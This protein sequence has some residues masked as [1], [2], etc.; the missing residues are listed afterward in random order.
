[1]IKLLK[2]DETEYW[3]KDFLKEHHI[4]RM[5]GVYIYDSIARV[6]CCET[7]PSYECYFVENQVDFESGHYEPD[8][9][10][11]VETN[12]DDEVKYFHCHT[13]EGS[14]TFKEGWFPRGKMGVV[15]IR[16]FSKESMKSFD[17]EGRRS[18]LIEEAHE[19]CH[20]N[21]V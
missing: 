6:Y 9:D 19:Y 14:P 16:G 21:C 8:I 4:R 2:I 5:F 18:E 13:I 15:S 7:T 10:T 17:L 11:L 12:D 3:D 20:Q 1:M